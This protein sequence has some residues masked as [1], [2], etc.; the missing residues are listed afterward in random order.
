MMS[1]ITASRTSEKVTAPLVLRELRSHDFA[2]LS[3]VDEAG[4]PNSA[5]VSYGV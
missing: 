4:R 2:V 3:T 5:G 1:G